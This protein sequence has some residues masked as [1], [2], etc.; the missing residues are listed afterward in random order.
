MAGE[1]LTDTASA[2]RDLVLS[3]AGDQDAYRRFLVWFSQRAEAAGAAAAVPT[4][5]RA[6][7]VRKCLHLAHRARHTFSGAVT[8]TAWADALILQAIPPARATRSSQ[9][10]RRRLWAAVAQS[11]AARWR[12]VR[13]FAEGGR[14]RSV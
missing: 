4:P 5:A 2:A 6:E 11:A 7:N 14:S 8:I 12:R 9:G 1:T 10:Q 13:G 3:Q